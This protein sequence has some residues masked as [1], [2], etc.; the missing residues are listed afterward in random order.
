MCEV[1]NDSHCEAYR[2]TE[3]VARKQHRCDGCGAIIRPGR[4]YAYASGVFEGYPF[5]THTCLPCERARK[6]FG[7][8]HRVGVAPDALSEHLE[9][10]IREGD[11]DT[12][13]W[14]I[15]YARLRSRSRRASVTAAGG[16]SDGR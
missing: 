7:K 11:G 1:Y 4:R 2:E 10:C 8:A 12:K 5:S 13:R 14:R 6:E 16:E 15:L 3:R 9:E